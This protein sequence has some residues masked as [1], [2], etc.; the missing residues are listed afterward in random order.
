MHL[1]R[2]ELY[3]GVAPEIL[4]DC[5][6]QLHEA[7]EDRISIVDLSKALGATLREGATVAAQMTEA[8]FFTAAESGVY[9]PTTKFSQLAN[10]HISDG[11]TRSEAEALLSR[12]VAR[13]Q[14]INA[15]P[16]VHECT[17]ECLV[18]F[19]SYLTDKPV[20]GDL[21][22]GIATRQVR[23]PREGRRSWGDL[24]REL[25]LRSPEAKVISA[26]RLRKPK[27]IS[28]H[29]LA[30]VQGLGTPYRLIFGVEP[31]RPIAASTTNRPTE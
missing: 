21:D 11:L 1:R 5:A 14:E 24:R 26:L 15:A 6:R 3:F 20:L 10:A 2:N 8:G 12:I 18:V 9:A 29:R 13:A 23:Q 17:I 28:I 22:L 19:G 25:M 30:E 4:L 27:L 16:Q 31:E 7:S